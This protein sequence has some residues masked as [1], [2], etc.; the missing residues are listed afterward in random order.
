MGPSKSR[1]WSNYGYNE[2][3]PPLPPVGNAYTRRVVRFSRTEMINSYRHTFFAAKA[4]FTTGLMPHVND[5][6]EHTLS[7]QQFKS[8]RFAF[9]LQGQEK[10]KLSTAVIRLCV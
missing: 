2:V 5:A 8:Q 6:L 3:T 7:Q 10:S 4:A 9:K 1:Y